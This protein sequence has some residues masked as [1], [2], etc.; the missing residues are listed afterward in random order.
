MPSC[1][2]VRLDIL[3]TNWFSFTLNR[4]D[5]ESKVLLIFN[6]LLRWEIL[7]HWISNHIFLEVKTFLELVVLLSFS[8]FDGFLHYF[9]PFLKLVVFVSFHYDLKREKKYNLSPKILSFFQYKNCIIH[10][11]KLFFGAKMDFIPFLK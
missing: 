10:S 8:F 4:L 3:W 5:S 9:F 7:S 2:D 6:W 11:F 1:V